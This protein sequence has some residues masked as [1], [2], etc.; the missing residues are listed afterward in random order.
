MG[1]GADCSSAQVCTSGF[2]CF[3]G[4]C[5]K[6][7]EYDSDC[8]EVDMTQG[9]LQT[10]WSSGDE[11][12]GVSVCAEICDPV[13]PQ[14]PTVPLRACPAGFGCSANAWGDSYCQKQTGTGVANSYCASDTDCVPGYYCADDYTC[15]KYCFSTTDC[16][17]GT[18]CNSFS[19]SYYAGFTE[20]GYCY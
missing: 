20:V 13:S 11:I 19:S 5:S 7:C 3:E 4:I 10:Y 14:H 12:W 6:Y 8:P 16:P 9:C 18:I 17:T 15:T 2:G 1:D